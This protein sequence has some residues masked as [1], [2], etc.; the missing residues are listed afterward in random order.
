MNYLVDTGNTCIKIPWRLHE[1]SWSSELKTDSTGKLISLSLLELGCTP[2]STSVEFFPFYREARY[3]K[4]WYSVTPIAVHC[5]VFSSLRVE[6]ITFY[7]KLSSL[8]HSSLAPSLSH[9]FGSFLH[10]NFWL[11]GFM[12]HTVYHCTLTAFTAKEYLAKKSHFRA[13][14]ITFCRLD[15]MVFC[16]TLSYWYS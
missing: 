6:L 13:K 8:S 9:W 2:N 3:A 12:R 4:G 16:L 11:K 5:F 15:L 14:L 7:S 1:R 10:A